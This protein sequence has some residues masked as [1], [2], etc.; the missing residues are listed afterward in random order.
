MLLFGDKFFISDVD[1]FSSSS[2]FFDFDVFFDTED[3]NDFFDV[4]DFNDFFGFI[5]SD[6]SFVFGI[7]ILI[8]ILIKKNIKIQKKKN[9]KIIS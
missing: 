6:F 7:Y 2:S 8:I 4:E 1:F 3:F 5:L 9:A